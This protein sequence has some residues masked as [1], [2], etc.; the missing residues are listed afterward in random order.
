MNTPRI[1]VRMKCDQNPENLSEFKITAFRE[2]GN[3]E[4]LAFCNLKA[5]GGFVILHSVI[6]S[7]QHRRK[8]VGRQIVRWAVDYARK[9]WPSRT[10]YIS[11]VPYSNNPGTQEELFSFYGG[12][13]F[14]RTPG[15][16]FEM[17]MK[18]IQ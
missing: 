16:P 18:G 7:S 11:A 17:T 10:I 8:G 9:E 13:G 1:S 4:P 5:F 12:I 15:H 6:V 14:E 2:F 3:P